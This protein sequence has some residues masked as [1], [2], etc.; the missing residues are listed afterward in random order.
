MKM[1][2]RKSPKTVFLFGGTS[3]PIVYSPHSRLYHPSHLSGKGLLLSPLYPSY[4][5]ADLSYS[6]A[7]RSSPMCLDNIERRGR[8]RASSSN[9]T[10]PQH[11]L[12]AL[13]PDDALLG[14]ARIYPERVDEVRIC[15]R[16]ERAHAPPHACAPRSKEPRARGKG[17]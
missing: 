2:I 16:E 15:Q 3:L 5:V 9:L 14:P 17:W 10:V 11:E 6:T 12:Y 7:F 13:T 8:R 1:I 4:L